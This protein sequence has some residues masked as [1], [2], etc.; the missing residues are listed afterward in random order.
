MQ[1]QTDN[2]NGSSITDDNIDRVAR[3]FFFQDQSFG[4]GS[5]DGFVVMYN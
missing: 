2:N 4:F 3:G 5:M 1:G